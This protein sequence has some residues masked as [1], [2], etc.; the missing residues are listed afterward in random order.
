MDNII[1]T[2]NLS[3]SYKGVKAVENVCLQVK[4]GEIYG[5][6]G[7]NGA[8]KTTTIR[9]LLG[10]IRPSSGSCFVNGQK[11]SAGNYEIWKQVGY[12]VETPYAYPDLTVR[13]NLEI[14]SNH[15][16]IQDKSTIDRVIER[17]DL[18]PYEHRKAKHLSMGNSQ[19]LG[20]A[21]ALLHEPQVLLLDEP[22]NG[23][24]PAGIVE[25]RELLQ[26]LAY[27]KGTT[28]FISSHILGEIS[29]IATKIGIIHQGQLVQEL[30]KE[31][32]DKNRIVKLLINTKDRNEA[33]ITLAGLGY[34]FWENENGVLETQSEDAV[35]H[36]ENI[37]KALVKGNHPPTLLLVEEEDLESYFL[38]VIGE[39]GGA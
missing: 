3:K 10:M 36:P 23:L 7:L 6:L 20:I 38:R 19:R 13:E 18:I 26:E 8:G 30:R 33:K 17:L 31:E 32:L 27:K 2:E 37:A 14:A 39:K 12:M 16:K 29:K 9:M 22:T 15:H 25:I 28:I 21:K 5:F 24:D 11:V 34:D 4:R 35:N 1:Y